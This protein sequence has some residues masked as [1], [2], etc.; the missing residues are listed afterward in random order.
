MKINQL[1]VGS[2]LSY[3]QM[4][5][6]LVIGLSYTPIMLRLLGQSEYGLYSTVSSTIAVLSIL[7]LGFNSSYIRFFSKYKLENDEEGIAKLNGLYLLIFILIGGIALLCGSYL[8]YNLD[9]VFADGLT[10][11]EYE[12][13]KVLMLLLTISLAISFP[14]SVFTS[15]ISAHERYVFLK[16]LGMLKTVIS[17]LVTL[18]LL[19]MGFRSI[20]MV[21][22]SL[23]IAVCT[24]IAYLIYVKKIL[25]VQ[26]SFRG[27]EKGIFQSLFGFTF[28][29]ALNMV[30]D[31]INNNIDKFLLGRFVGTTAVAVYA[32]GYTF[33]QYYIMLSVAVSN[34]F[35][36]RI[37]RI[38]NLTKDN[39]AV[40]RGQLT[41][42]FI[43]VGR[44]QFM[45]LSLVT[46]GFLFFGRQFIMLWAGEG[47]EEA[48]Y[49]ALALMLASSIA[50]IQNLGIEIQR[51]QNR[52]QF[53]SIAYTIMA[54]LNLALSI[55]L[56]PRYGVLGVVVGTV[57]ALI[58]A[59]GVIMNI[60]YHKKC[61]IN[62]FSFWQSILR[63]SAS[64]IIP[65][66]CGYGLTYI[67]ELCS[68]PALV[69]G[70][71]V[72]TMIYCGNVWFLGMNE[73]ERSLIRKPVRKVLGR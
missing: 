20:A 51:A 46:T 22:A 4:F 9:I 70:I 68:V 11:Q 29:I 21:V 41:E 39:L 18:P 25:H 43:K 31:Q 27:F 49:I 47:Y 37:H 65:M 40:Q 54:M 26:F 3:C 57:I 32:V 6:N 60:Y 36:P 38:V 30:V 19:L 5:L 53:R 66:F 42:L 58:L 62:I 71:L 2:L 45:I 63:L 64:L 48:Y 1:K 56:C 15:I 28:F 50:L 35:V 61:N 69:G 34:V 17:P 73:Y 33:Y 16:L 23:C 10:M 72:Y 8:T 12:I 52:H 59:N 24:D 13:A 7:N 44:I 67:W 14:M 55:Y